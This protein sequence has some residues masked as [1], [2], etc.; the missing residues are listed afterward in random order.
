[1]SEVVGL[2]ADMGVR[3]VVD[4]AAM[5][6][7]PSPSPTVWRKRLHADGPAEAARVTSI[8]RFDPGGAF[9]AHD[10]PDGEE[11]LVLDGVFSDELG[12]YP[13]GTHI[14]NPEGFRH[15]P[16]SRQGCTLFVKLRQYAGAGRPRQQRHTRALAWEERRGGQTAEMPLYSQ[17]GYEGR[18]SLIRFAPGAGAPRHGH[19]FGEEVLI[20]E[21]TME[22]E[23]GTYGPGTWIRSPVGSMHKPFSRD[24]CVFFLKT[25]SV[26]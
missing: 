24:G 18:T 23:L 16:F 9:P 6:W 22:D 12:D 14:L 8:V 7:E 10:H 19:P 25:G 20:L 11:I 21:G 17:D 4:T 15:A 5:G 13:A 2:N 3:V 1:M 26:L